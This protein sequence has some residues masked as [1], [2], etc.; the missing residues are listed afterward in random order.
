M[1]L[2]D[3]QLKHMKNI[4]F[5]KK[6]EQENAE[7]FYKSALQETMAFPFNSPIREEYKS[8]EPPKNKPP[9]YPSPPNIHPQIYSSEEKDLGGTHSSI[10]NQNRIDQHIAELE[11]DN[12][13]LKAKHQNAFLAE[14]PMKIVN[15]QLPFEGTFSASEDT[16]HR[17]TAGEVNFGTV[18]TEQREQLDQ[19]RIQDIQR[20]VRQKFDR[21]R[22]EAEPMAMR[23]YKQLRGFKRDRSDSPAN[24]EAR[25]LM[26]GIMR[27]PQQQY[28]KHLLQAQAVEREQV[29][30]Q[31]QD[32]VQ[33]VLEEEKV[34]ASQSRSLSP[35]KENIVEQIFGQDIKRRANQVIEASEVLD[36]S[37]A[38]RPNFLKDIVSHLAE[39]KAKEVEVEAEE[40]VVVVED[41][42]L[43]MLHGT[44]FDTRSPNK[45]N[46]PQNVSNELLSKSLNPESPSFQENNDISL[47]S[48]YPKPTGKGQ[49]ISFNNLLDQK[50]ASQS[51]TKE[52]QP[53]PRNTIRTPNTFKRLVTS[54]NTK[55][56]T[57]LEGALSFSEHNSQL[58]TSSV[59][60]QD[61]KTTRLKP[62][63][64][65][66]LR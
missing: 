15:E 16:L 33:Q 36:E 54:S 37:G 8:E 47:H 58:K 20:D 7:I 12:P 4:D 3:R 21:V 59:H 17:A 39:R 9:K 48:I 44:R 18:E 66:E 10:E 14:N 35:Y 51:F 42:G 40:E 32:V 46:D 6:I 64:S 50:K 1:D 43:E 57:P 60:F 53:G 56:R 52:N 29:V 22:G 31:E 34:S 61:P 28:A 27:N 24:K 23:F 19:E 11:K 2:E 62:N 26:K 25:E 38:L 65:Q 13:Y 49:N 63:P 45:Q 5:Q 41:N 30:Q 55:G